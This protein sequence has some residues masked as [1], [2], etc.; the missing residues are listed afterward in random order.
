MCFRT[1][2][3]FLLFPFFASRGVPIE[4]RRS[5]AA[6]PVLAPMRDSSVLVPVRDSS[7]FV[8]MRDSSVLVP[9]RD[10]VCP[11]LVLSTVGPFALC[12]RIPCLSFIVLLFAQDRHC[13]PLN[14]FVRCVA[15][16]APTAPCNN[17][18]DCPPATRSDTAASSLVVT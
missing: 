11:S 13:S 9:V 3:L 14:E 5:P 15:C 16:C 6:H 10:I 4:S 7:V 18:L 8:P 12:L 17:V 2:S 1:I